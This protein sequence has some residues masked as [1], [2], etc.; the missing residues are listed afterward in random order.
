MDTV[1]TQTVS[2]KWYVIDANGKPTGRIAMEAARILQGKNKPTWAPHLDNGD[3]VIVVNADKVIMTG[4]K[5]KQMIYYR[6]TGYKGGLKE[7]TFEK[8][9]I[10]APERVIE[11]AVKGMLPQGRLGRQM[12]R[13]LK[14]YTGATHPHSAQNPVECKL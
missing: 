8:M 6:Y 11:H 14:V 1:F 12:Y 4:K 13:K 3:F 7:T 5:D 10:K 9:M 2:R